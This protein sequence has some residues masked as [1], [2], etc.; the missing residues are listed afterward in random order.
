M[1]ADDLNL[2]DLLVVVAKR[3]RVVVGGSIAVGVLAFGASLMLTPQFTARTT[4]IPPQSGASAGM[5]AALSTLGPLAGLAVGG[6]SGRSAETYVSLL[7]SRT[8]GQQLIKRH[9]LKELYGAS[10][11]FEAIDALSQRTRVEYSKRDGIVT[12]EFDDADPSRAALIANDYVNE[13]GK[14]VGAMALTDAKR[15]RV[16]LEQELEQSRKKLAE[17]QNALQSVGF[18]QGA[19]KAEPRAAADEYSRVKAE[20]ASTEVRIK[21]MRS[22]LVDSAP[23]IQSLSAIS[24]ALRRQLEI[25]EQKSNP[26]QAQDY[27]S[28][29]REF[30][31]QE[32]LFEQIAKQ[33]EAAR[34]EESREDNT[35]QIIDVAQVPEWKSKPKRALVAVAATLIAAVLL[36]AMVVAQQLRS[37]GRPAPSR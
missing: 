31:Y 11:D 33:F 19:L 10:F 28:R 25:L 26:T 13:L 7:K 6:S 36:S 9:Q 16:F 18:D 14:M 4:F 5:N 20:L 17:A 21:A 34:L 32:A 35:I 27:V 15:H 24:A 29:Y 22:R 12:L 8:L 2:I 23:E 30:K 3:W 37:L 1:S